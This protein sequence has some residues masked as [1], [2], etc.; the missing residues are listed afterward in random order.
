LISDAL[1]AEG[2]KAGIVA[3]IQDHLRNDRRFLQTLELVA[4]INRE[5]GLGSD[6]GPRGVVIHIHTNLKPGELRRRYEQE[7]AEE[8]KR[9][10]R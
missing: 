5:I 6:E 9:G 3:K 8:Q 1:A 4:R 7:Q 2:V 10:G